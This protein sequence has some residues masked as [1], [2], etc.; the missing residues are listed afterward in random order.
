MINICETD[1][2][3]DGWLDGQM[4]GWT[5]LTLGINGGT[6]TL[7]GEAV[8]AAGDSRAARSPLKGVPD[9]PFL[10]PPLVG[11]EGRKSRPGQSPCW[12]H[13]QRAM[14]VSVVTNQGCEMLKCGSTKRT[15]AN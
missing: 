5:P 2:W 9:T 13:Y 14:D 10:S 7:L 3:L 8:A 4:T 12:I 15:S 6:G 11:E 1:G